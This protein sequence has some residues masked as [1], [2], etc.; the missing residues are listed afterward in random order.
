MKAKTKRNEHNPILTP[1]FFMTF[2]DTPIKN[3][4]T[5]TFFA[6]ARELQKYQDAY[7]IS[8]A[9]VQQLPEVVNTRHKH[10]LMVI[11]LAGGVGQG[12]QGIQGIQ[13]R[14]CDHRSVA[15]VEVS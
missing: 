5:S 2:I 7:G 13:G 1:F 15:G 11:P 9:Q 10:S 12:I 14:P 3:K 8:S 4:L 6:K